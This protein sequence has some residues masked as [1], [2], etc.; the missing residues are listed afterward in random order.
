MK[1]AET[2]FRTTEASKPPDLVLINSL[3]PWHQAW[4]SYARWPPSRPDVR[5]A[6]FVWRDVD[7]STKATRPNLKRPDNSTLRFKR[8]AHEALALWVFGIGKL[9]AGLSAQQSPPK[10]A[11]PERQNT[12]AAR[13]WTIPT[14][15]KTPKARNGLPD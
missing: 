9:G 2:K 11:L 6:V 3:R 14:A 15:C 13:L 10:S 8:Y 7:P 4:R 1:R 12:Q 5:C